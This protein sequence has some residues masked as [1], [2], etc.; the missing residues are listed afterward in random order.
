[1]DDTGLTAPDLNPKADSKA[2]TIAGKFG[3]NGLDNGFFEKTSCVGTLDAGN[4]WTS[5]WTV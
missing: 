2:L 1:M 4:H 3:V 5:G